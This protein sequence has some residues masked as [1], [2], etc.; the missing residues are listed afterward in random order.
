MTHFTLPALAA[1]AFVVSGLLAAPLAQ[2][3]GNPRFTIERPG[4]VAAGTGAA[5]FTLRAPDML[6]P[7]P[8]A[9]PATANSQVH[10]PGGGGFGGGDQCDASNYDENWQDTLCETRGPRQVIPLGCVVN[11]V[12][13]GIDLRGGTSDTGKRIVSG[14]RKVIPVVAAEAGTIAN[15]SSF[16]VTLR[17]GDGRKYQ[18]LHLD[19]V[20]LEVKVGDRVAKG[21]VLGFMDNDFGGTATTFHLHIEHWVNIPGRG[22]VPVP[23][24]CDLAEAYS[25]LHGKPYDVVGGGQRCDGAA[26]TPLTVVD[27]PA[28]GTDKLVSFWDHN[29][30][31]MGLL[32][33]GDRRTI[34]YMTPRPALAGIVE[35][36]DV[37]F[38]GRKDGNRYVGKARVFSS[39]CPP[40]AFDVSG[41]I[42]AEGRKV[43]LTGDAPQRNAACDTVGRAAQTLTFDFLRQK[44]QAVVSEP[45]CGPDPA[46][47]QSLTEKTR[48]WGAITMFVPFESWLPYIRDWPGLRLDASGRPMDMGRDSFGG[49]LPAFDTDEAGVG[50]WWYWL[51]VRKGFGEAGEPVAQ[52]TFRQIA[53][54]IAGD[55]ASAAALAA[56]TNAYTGLSARYFGQ[57]VGLDVPLD[58]TD[59]A[60]R[61]ALGQVMFHHE[62]GR[63]PL[64]SRDIFDRGISFGG[65]VMKETFKGLDAYRADC[66]IDGSDVV[67]SDVTTPEP[68]PAAGPAPDLAAQITALET[69]LATL[70]TET[71]TAK[72]ANAQLTELVTDL[73]SRLVDIAKIAQP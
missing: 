54:G 73:R 55:D 27:E 57:A 59:A 3:I 63:P 18:Y 12:H 33:D 26:A 10:S 28:L 72:R 13:Q 51:L 49:F 46:Q 58:L 71:E 68:N 47:R 56:Y 50:I 19:M 45:G 39:Q 2:T 44:G 43:E 30:S 29:G 11:T 8:K 41:P 60:K 65:D 48:N 36:G 6:F 16:V 22:I 1:L 14:E 69:R 53:R 61:W 24:Y 67:A 37:L 62:A 42:L 38:N 66:A 31:E 20:R 34:V 15:I 4:K 9:F 70:E 64:I 40:E 25:R 35:A 21:D 7:I 5:D 23:L 52:P 17:I 32:A